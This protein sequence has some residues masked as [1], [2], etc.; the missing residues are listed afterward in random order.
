MKNHQNKYIID[1]CPILGKKAIIL[2]TFLFDLDGTLLPIDG[3]T[4]EREYF[5]RLCEM[6]KNEFEPELTVKYMWEAT[7]HMVINNEAEKT[8][9]DVF[10]K[11]FSE[12]TNRDADVMYDLFLNFYA[13]NYRTM[14]ELVAPSEYIASSIKLLK[15]KGYRLIVATNPLF[16]VEAIDERIK[17]AGLDKSD[18]DYITSFEY[19]HFCK[20]NI[21]YYKEILSIINKKPEDCIMVG[22]D[23]QEDLIAGELGIKTFLIEEHIINRKQTAPVSDYNGTYQDF[24]SFVCELPDVK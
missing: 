11:K 6:L 3:D 16:P 23:V 22:N 17:W 8:N 2:N 7:K 5:K 18:F 24:Y 4:F 21:N 12:L 13:G 14:G 15:Q 20:P 1:K 9:K 19:M 10:M